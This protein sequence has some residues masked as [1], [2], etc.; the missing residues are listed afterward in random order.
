MKG[1]VIGFDAD[2]NTGA[3]SGH[4]GNRYD[5]ATQNWRGRACRGMAMSSTLPHPPTAVDIYLLEPQ[6]IR[7]R[8]WPFY[9]SPS[10]RISRSQFWL[11]GM[12]PIYG[13]LIGLYIVIA[14]AGAAT[15]RSL[16]ASSASS[17]R[18]TRWRFSGRAS[19]SW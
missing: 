16:P 6:Y 18:S 10:G 1:N 3:I 19:R 4:D 12:L 13:I 5:F 7:Q 17:R 9:F 8:F 11:R 2:T 15:A 14:I